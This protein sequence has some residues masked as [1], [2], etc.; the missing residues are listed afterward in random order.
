MEMAFSAHHLQEDFEPLRGA[1]PL[2]K[3]QLPQAAPGRAHLSDPVG[4][5][6]GIVHALVLR[7]VSLAKHGRDPKQLSDC[8]QQLHRH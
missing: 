8:L 7:T 6:W 3:W 2:L 4:E 5:Q 1:G